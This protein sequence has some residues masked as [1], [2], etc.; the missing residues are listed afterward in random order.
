MPPRHPFPMRIGLNPKAQANKEA[1]RQK[2]LQLKDSSGIARA[3]AERERGHYNFLI[4]KKQFV[5]ANF[6]MQSP[7]YRHKF[8][9]IIYFIPERGK[10]HIS[11]G[12]LLFDLTGNRIA[13]NFEIMHSAP[14]VF[15]RMPWG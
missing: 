12:K 11:I 4:G 7:L 15:N 5:V 2:L 3:F 8:C 13:E 9:G 1:M 6:S 10:T 14:K